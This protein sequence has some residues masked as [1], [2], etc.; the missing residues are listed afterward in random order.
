M[1]IVEMSLPE[2]SELKAITINGC[3][4]VESK[5]DEA[6][7]AARRRARKSRWETSSSSQDPPKK[8]LCSVLLSGELGSNPNHSAPQVSTDNSKIPGNTLST[9]I[10]TS[11]MSEKEQQ[12][13]VLR[14]QIQEATLKLSQP[15]YGIPPNPRD[16]S[17][18]PEPIYN[19]K[20]I[21]INTREDRTKSRLIQQRN[22]AITKIKE[23]DPTYQPP[24]AYKYKNLDLEDR[25]MIPADE[26]PHI[27][28]MGLILGP[29]GRS[30]E[31]LSKRTN[32]QIIIRGKGTL[33]SGMTGILKSGTKVEA[34]EDPMHALIKGQTAEDV[35]KAVKEIEDIIH[36][37]IYQPDSEKAVA[38]RAKTMHDLAVLNGTLRD[39]DLKCLNC[40]KWGHNAWEC[41]EGSNFTS[42]VICSACGGIGHVTS[43]CRQRRPGALFNQTK[44]KKDS[45]QIDSEYEH[46]LTDMGFDPKKESKKDD[47]YAPPVG[48]LSKVGAPLMLTYGSGASGAASA[49]SRAVSAGQCPGGSLTALGKSIFGGKLT[50]MTAGFKSHDEREMERLKKVDEWHNRPIPMEWQVEK[51]EKEMINQN[52]QYMRHLKLQAQAEKQRKQ[53]Q[54]YQFTA[55]PPPP[56]AP[57]FSSSA[58]SP[59][60]NP[61]SVVPPEDLPDLQHDPFSGFKRL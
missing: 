5:E 34:M 22:A 17:P 23:I 48:D 6:K 54:S 4:L 36:L 7:R 25:V 60:M 30:L 42:S 59:K 3:I 52:E 53:F 32:C 35:K 55:P 14:L 49:H 12:I 16:R 18:S 58:D 26:H 10:D 28:F 9:M 24:S 38:L 46:F 39:I 13:Y 51:M 31:E 21:R 57:T 29:R 40:G 11:Q 44:G 45:N 1:T 56:G 8:K 47:K 43:D 19:N 41:S 15:N 61:E 2:T 33:K 20:G 37:Q 50:R 27:N